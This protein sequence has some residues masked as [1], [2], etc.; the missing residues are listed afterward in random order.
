MW[1]L[2]ALIAPFFWA[3][4]NL[5]DSS[6]SNKSFR[7]TY[8]LI[9]YS[10]VV[11][12]PIAVIIGLFTHARFPTSGELPFVIAIG[13]LDI[14]YR[15]PYYKALQH[16]D[17]SVTVSLFSLGKFFTPLLAFLFAGELLAPREYLGFALILASSIALTITFNKAGRG[18]TINRSFWYMLLAAGII[19]P[20]AVIW[21]VVFEKTGMP[22]QTGFVWSGIASLLCIIT[23]LLVGR[24]RRQVVSEFPTLWLVKKQFL[25]SEVALTTANLFYVMAL[26]T[27]P[28][29]LVQ[30][31]TS[32]Q[33]FIVL[34]YAWL[35]SSILPKGV[36]EQLTRG[37]TVKKIALFSIM[38]V[39]ILLIRA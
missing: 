17:A 23:F 36:F 4:A 8:P 32:I 12:V 37:S 10:T 5:F 1:F 15:F 6:L 39:G 28:A 20:E 14:L 19:L 25:G 21:R 26:V 7:G 2:F 33:P 38:L 16:S 30:G 13:V 11:A 29:T 34:A 35:F 3:T 24:L 27:G 9:F 22:W 31:I 18:F